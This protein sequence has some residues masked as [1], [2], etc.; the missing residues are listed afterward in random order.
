MSFGRDSIMLMFGLRRT[1]VTNGRVS[2][3]SPAKKTTKVV[4]AEE[5]FGGEADIFADLDFGAELAGVSMDVDGE[6][7]L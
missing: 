4:K 5:S 3:T 6:E 2:K 7:F 1:A